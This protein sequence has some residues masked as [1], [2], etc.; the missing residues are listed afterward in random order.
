MDLSNL[1]AG[2]HV[3]FA[4]T[5]NF[6]SKA[7]D[8][9]LMKFS[10]ERITID[11][12]AN[13]VIQCNGADLWDGK[14]SN[15]GTLKPKA[16]SLH[17]LNHSVVRGLNI[18]NTPEQAISILADNLELYDIKIKNTDPKGLAHN[19]DAFDIGNSNNIWI[20]GAIIDNQDDCVAINSGK[21][22]T[23]I[24]GS[25]SGGHGLSVGSV[26]GRDNNVVDGVFFLHSKVTNSQNGVRIKTVA[27]APS[28]T[29][30]NIHF[31]DITLSG[32]TDFGVVIVQNYVNSGPKPTDPG[33]KIPI[34]NVVMKQIRG[35]VTS[36]AVGTEIICGNCKNF[37]PWDVQL[38]SG[39]KGDCK[40]APAGV[41]C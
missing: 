7:F 25:C 31:E 6:A 4:G 38:T 11:G 26:G 16:L 41:T 13:H 22:I 32:I 40:G 29:V 21:N 8:G 35:S 28:G 18:Q 9:F 2:A 14:G 3:T 23:F 27:T 39:K 20:Q 36:N 5:T 37:T 15:G 10:G 34:T 1:K 30:N 24:G 33:T 17:K 19:T 12:T